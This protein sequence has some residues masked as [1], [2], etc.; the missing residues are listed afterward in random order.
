M[1]C[2]IYYSVQARRDLDAI[3]EG[4]LNASGDVDTADRYIAALIQKISDKKD[5]PLRRELI[6][7]Y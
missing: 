7:K 4:V 1:I 6:R 2:Q 5:F 3:W